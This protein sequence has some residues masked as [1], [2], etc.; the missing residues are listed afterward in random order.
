MPK[1]PPKI[2][3]RKEHL[4]RIFNKEFTPIVSYQLP[5]TLRKQLN[6]GKL[7]SVERGT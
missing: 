6:A 2:E 1:N 7:R 5:S 4:E 3:N